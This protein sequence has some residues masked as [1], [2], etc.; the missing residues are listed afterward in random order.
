MAGY[1]DGNVTVRQV[2]F[3]VDVGAGRRSG[4]DCVVR[5]GR[6]VVA[7]TVRGQGSQGLGHRPGRGSASVPR[8]CGSAQ[9]AP[10]LPD[11][12]LLMSTHVFPPPTHRSEAEVSV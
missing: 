5:S 2:K 3:A 11:Q 1:L 7:E 10:R 9:G 6:R 8:A 4:G 12:F